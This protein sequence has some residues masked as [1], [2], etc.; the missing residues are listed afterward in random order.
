MQMSGAF[1]GGAGATGV[2]LRTDGSVPASAV[3]DSIR[4][5]IASTNAEQV[6]FGTQTMQSIISDTLAQ[7]RF[8]MILLGSFAALALVLASIGI[9]GAISYI[10]TRRTQEIGIRMAL[11]AKPD[12]VL[13]MV[14]LDGA[15]LA[16][17]GIVLGLIVALALTR[18]MSNMLY[19]VSATDPAT[20]AAISISLLMVAVAACYVPASRAMHVDPVVALRND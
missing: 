10:V 17:A 4:S 7:R 16:G 14:L 2:L 20:F 19:G 15:R 8:S 9:Y 6:I 3:M 13:R 1:M 12:D 5:Q 11:G 18:L